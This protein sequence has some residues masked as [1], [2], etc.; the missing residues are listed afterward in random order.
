MLC[1]PSHSASAA[2]R[3]L[4]LWY[5]K[6]VPVLLPFSILSNILLASDSLSAFG[7]WIG[8]L[9]Q[10]I[11]P[12]STE[13]FYPLI[14]GFLFGFPMGG[15]ITSQ[16]IR[17]KKLSHE[18]GLCCFCISNNIGPAFLQG[19]LA[20]QMYYI[21]FPVWILFL[22]LYLPPLLLGRIWLSRL[23]HF[24]SGEKAGKSKKSASKSQITFEIIDAGILNGFEILTRIGGYVMLFSILADMLRHIPYLPTTLQCI[25]I[26]CIEITNGSHALAE[27][28]FSPL[29]KQVLALTFVAF[30]GI[31]GFF[32]ASSF[33]KSAS[34]SM[35]SYFY[36]KLLCTLITAVCSLLF[37]SVF[38]SML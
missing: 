30:G 3:G 13:A 16:M 20:T 10:R 15:Q 19:V 37:F 24:H 21:Q 34:L 28:P 29:V 5:Q 18:E 6:L 27:S 1:Y 25:M 38:P 23:H 17:Q 12:L 7:K 32:Q 2:A 35:K 36:F 11:Y 8:P 26:G 9:L 31:S 14:A 4:L 22:L 33:A